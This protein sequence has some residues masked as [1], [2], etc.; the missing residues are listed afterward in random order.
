M[1][2]AQVHAVTGQQHQ[3]AEGWYDRFVFFFNFKK[4]LENIGSLFLRYNEGIKGLS[5]G[6]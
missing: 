6:S 5:D 3:A 2:M 4:T 1:E